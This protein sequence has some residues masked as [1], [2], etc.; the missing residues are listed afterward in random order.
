MDFDEQHTSVVR[1][2]LLALK[3][4]WWLVAI[5]LAV[6]LGAALTYSYLRT[7]MYSS[8]AVLTYQRQTD[9]SS[10]LSGLTYTPTLDTDREL[11]TSAD[12]LTGDLMKNRV[13]RTLAG[14]G[15]S[16][17][18]GTKITAEAVADTNALDITAV[19]PSA[20]NAADI[21]N[22]YADG[23]VSYRLALML[24]QFKQAGRIIASKLSRYQTPQSRQDA[25]YYQLASRQQDLRVMQAL[26]TG[27]YRVAEPATPATQPFAPKPMTDALLGLVIGLIGGIVAVFLAEQ[28][29]VR[30]RSQ[31]EI[32][33]AMRLPI[34]GRLPR[35]SRDASREPGL[36]VLRDPDGQSAEAFRILRGN[37][38]YVAV[39]SEMQS[40]LVT[41]SALG[42]GK[43]TTACS[44]AVT[45]V[46]TGKRVVLVDGDLR[47]SSVHKQ[48]ELPNRIGLTSVAAEHATL[49]EALQTVVLS[50]DADGG[51][52]TADGSS[53]GPAATLTVLTAGPL[54]PNPNE[55]VASERMAAII[56]QLEG[57]ADLVIVDSPP[58]MAVGDAGALAAKVDGILLVM[59][60][61]RVTRSSL[62]YAAEFVNPL[63]CRK[64]GIVV[65]NLQFEGAGYRYEYRSDRKA[66]AHS[67]PATAPPSQSI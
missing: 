47:R 44:L 1:D 59:R 21:A 4:R 38:D 10:A 61:G 48:F 24:D 65:T 28:L 17:G 13:A 41:S 46:R 7:P 22:A 19:S 42:E 49:E 51:G 55:I 23:F 26:A 3:R 25:G 39:D 34:V 32:S 27:N 5:A 62:R 60:L 52:Q 8:T 58:F 66:G 40:F 64:L 36:V 50:G 20:Q 16:L 18:N 31:E 6:A 14:Q 9:V 15:R 29:D 56:K 45:L 37:L 2:Y 11:K 63:P 53:G 54:P 57:Q 33:R 35:P 12:L 43:T 67:K 30:V